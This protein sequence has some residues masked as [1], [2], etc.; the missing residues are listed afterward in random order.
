MDTPRTSIAQAQQR[1][2][3]EQLRARGITSPRVLSAMAKVPREQFTPRTE[4]VEAYADRAWPIDCSQTISQ[5]FIVGMM[6]QALD[7][8]GSERVLEVGTGSGYQAAVLAE[9]AARVITIERH[10]ELARQASQLLSWLGYDNVKV[11]VGDGSLGWPA[12]APYDRIIVT[13]AGR[14]PPPA[15]LAQLSDGGLLVMPVGETDIQQLIRL[16]KQGNQFHR[17]ELSGCR[18][19]PLVGQ[20]GWPEQN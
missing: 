8:S 19:V 9:I 15:L 20:Q 10:P 18:F 1:M 16:E 12:E 13:A 7:L 3:D 5:P 6:T 11:M 2:L 17:Q 4:P 14:Q